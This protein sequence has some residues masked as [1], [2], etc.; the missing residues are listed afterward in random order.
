MID[1]KHKLREMDLKLLKNGHLFDERQL[2]MA[3]RGSL[4]PLKILVQDSDTHEARISS[5]LNMVNQVNVR[6][7]ERN[8]TI[9][10]HACDVILSELD[11]VANAHH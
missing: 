1:T 11:E 8:S 6:Y 7:R 4:K 5:I 3:R 10:N 9:L 2:K